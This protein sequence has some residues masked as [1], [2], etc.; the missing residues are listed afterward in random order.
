MQRRR[1]AEV[2]E[3]HD[4]FYSSISELNNPPDSKSWFYP[5]ERDKA[6]LIRTIQESVTRRAPFSPGMKPR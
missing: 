3:L 4:V 2:D 5:F 1:T 6:K